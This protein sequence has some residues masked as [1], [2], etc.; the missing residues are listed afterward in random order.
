MMKLPTINR[1]CRWLCFG[2]VKNIYGCYIGFFIA[3][4]FALSFGIVFGLDWG[5]GFVIYLLH[6]LFDLN[7]EKTLIIK[8]MI[9]FMIA[10]GAMT[11]IVIGC[12]PFLA[13]GANIGNLIGYL[14]SKA[15][16]R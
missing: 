12:L 15:I 7:S 6:I 14:I 10:L 3:L 8:L 1:F 4:P 2:K 11:S 16:K 5:G 13:I 9:F